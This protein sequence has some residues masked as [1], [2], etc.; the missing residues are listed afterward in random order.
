MLILPIKISFP[1]QID[2]IKADL[3]KY[4]LE[5]KS[6]HRVEALARAL[7]FKT[8]AALRARNLFKYPIDTQ[9]NW[10]AFRDYLKDKGFNPTAK[11][12]YLAGGRDAIRLM[13]NVPILEP[14]LTREGIG[15]DINRPKGETP[16]QFSMRFHDARMAM[17]LD[18]SVEEFLRS[19]TF[20]SRIKP[21]RTITTKSN[22]YNLKHIAEKVDLIYPDGEVSLAKYVHT[23]NLIAAALH[24]GFRY[25]K[26]KSPHT[27]NF[28]MLQRS[29][30]TL[31]QEIRPEIY[32]K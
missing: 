25:R 1:E 2:S 22:A 16:Q 10:P 26:Y 21:T 15:I 4:Y 8:Y 23:G 20:V 29:I 31:D 3:T 18:S 30:V 5:I 11:P 17:L 24:A 6:S 12:L 32:K 9:V 27:V 13:L 28:N 14:S 7:G 19:Y